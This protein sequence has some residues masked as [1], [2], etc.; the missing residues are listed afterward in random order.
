VKKEMLFQFVRFC[1][2]GLVNTGI[3]TG[4]YLLFLRAGMGLSLSY[5]LSYLLGMISSFLLNMFWTFGVRCWEG[6]VAVRFVAANVAVAWFGEWLLRAAVD[7]AHVPAAW[8][9]L[10]TLI[11]TTLLNFLLGKYWVFR[12]RA[13]AE[14]LGR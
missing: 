6:S 14:G 2:T 5:G 13:V 11:P 10:L 9:Q 3:S 12:V 7:Q 8:A 1:L 4:S